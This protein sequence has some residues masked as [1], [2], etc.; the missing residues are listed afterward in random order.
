MRGMLKDFGQAAVEAS[1]KQFVT[2]LTGMH[3]NARF[4]PVQGQRRNPGFNIGKG[5]TE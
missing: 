4:A 3:A 2:V 1:I 5:H